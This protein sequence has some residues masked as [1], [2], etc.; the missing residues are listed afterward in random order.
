[1]VHAFLKTSSKEK[2]L[3]SGVQKKPSGVCT[4]EGWPL[5]SKKVQFF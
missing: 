5:N 2:P 3:A 4:P 1:M